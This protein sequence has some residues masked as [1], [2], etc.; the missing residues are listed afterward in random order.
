MSEIKTSKQSPRFEN[1]KI[2][3]FE[4]DTFVLQFLV[5]LVESETNEPLTILPSD[6]IVVCFY[7]NNIPITKF[8]YNNLKEGE[9]ICLDFSSDVS[10]K[11]KEGTYTYTITYI[12]DSRTTIVA[13]NIAE[14]Q[15]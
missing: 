4:N 7:K 12:G 6:E 14:V 10:K 5:N 15:K 9:P 13:K 11:F 1:G 3:W 8:C 2:C